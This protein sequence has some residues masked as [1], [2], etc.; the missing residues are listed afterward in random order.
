[1]SKPFSSNL[2]FIVLSQQRRRM[3]ERVRLHYG[4]TRAAATAPNPTA[5]LLELG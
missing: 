5:G 1:M 3:L 4:Q 2:E